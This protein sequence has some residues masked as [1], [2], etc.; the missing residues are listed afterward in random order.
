[1]KKR[2]LYETYKNH[3]NKPRA[4]CKTSVNGKLG[5]TGEGAEV[6]AVSN[7]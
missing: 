6:V 2:G 4:A 3:V 5:A 7:L 1:M